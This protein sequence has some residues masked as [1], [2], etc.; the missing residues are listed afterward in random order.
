MVKYYNDLPLPEHYQANYA[1]LRGCAKVCSRLYVDM[2]VYMYNMYANFQEKIFVKTSRKKFQTFH[3]CIV[4]TI[5]WSGVCF[6]NS[7][8]IICLK[9]LSYKVPMYVSISIQKNVPKI[10]ESDFLPAPPRTL[11]VCKYL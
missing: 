3:C 10:K 9:K 7:P 4:T 5:K 11:S 8:Q 2:F 6:Q 1:L